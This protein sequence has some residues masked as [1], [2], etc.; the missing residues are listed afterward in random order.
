MSFEIIKWSLISLLLIILIHYLFI[1]FKDNLTIPKTKDLVTKPLEK[2]KTMEKIIDNKFTKI[3]S[4]KLDSNNINKIDGTT[5]LNKLDEISNTN[6][7][8]PSQNIYNINGATKLENLNNE[9]NMKDELKCFFNNLN[10]I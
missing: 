1:F 5:M 4:N 7:L 3:K 6:N 8:L 10:N 9:D 2:Y